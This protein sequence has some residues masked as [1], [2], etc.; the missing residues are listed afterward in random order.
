MRE[1]TPRARRADRGTTE[2]GV[3]DQDPTA[4]TEAAVTADEPVRTPASVRRGAKRRRKLVVSGVSAVVVVSL[5]G[6]GAAFAANRG[7]A[8]TY[9]TATATTG[10]VT[11]TVDAAGTVASAARADAAFSVAGTV[12]TVAVGVGDSVSAGDVLATLDLTE[13][14]DAVESAQE[15]LARAEQTLEDDLASQTSSSSTAAGLSSSAS[16][17]TSTS[18]RTSGTSA[19]IASITST[20]SS[21]TS[22]VSQ[23]VARVAGSSPVVTQAVATTTPSAAASSASAGGASPSAEVAQ[24]LEAVELAQQALLDGYDAATAAL[25]SSS[26]SIVG[27]QEACAAFLAATD[28]DLPSAPAGGEADEADDDTG[29]GAPAQDETSADRVDLEAALTT[30][31][32]AIT[33]ALGA[34]TDVDGAQHSL[35]DLAAQLDA[36]IQTAQEALA[37][38]QAGGSEGQTPG[39]SG[40]SGTGSGGSGTS[41]GSSGTPAGPSS[42]D[43]GSGSGV[44]GPGGASGTGGSGSGTT[45]P[46]SGGSATS[47][48]AASA[49]Q[50]LADR[51]AIDLAEAQV[52][53]AQ[54][55]AQRS[56]LTSPIA[57]TVAQ[58]ALAVGDQVEASSTSAVVTVLG[59]D[60]YVVETTVPLTAVVSLAV[61]Q[62][63][64]VTVSDDP[65]VRTGTV[66]SIGVL[67]TS[68]S[69][70]PEYPVTISLDPQDETLYE[71]SSAQ[72]SITVAGGT[73]VLVVPTSAVRATGTARTVAVLRDGKVTDVTVEVGAV[74]QETTEITSGLDAGDEVILADLTQEIVTDEES[75]TGLTGLGDSGSPQQRGQM[76]SGGG[77]Q[78]PA[79]GTGGPPS[80]G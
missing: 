38:D 15:T 47:Q 12:A 34:Q 62:E 3:A 78:F 72:A 11:Q 51:A 69:S 74:G 10:E 40:D 4:A 55:D 79:G 61:G 54:A 57:G 52:A 25:E 22:G 6:A 9:R 35:L 56:T 8:G 64:A 17:S 41:G 39:S 75:S 27:S 43:G 30:C 28:E 58:V 65:T 31:Q 29:A 68:T 44:T 46:T 2:Q 45:G 42:G 36:A 32:E 59:A 24:A 63:A 67:S 37:A 50:V 16:S 53:I 26:T 20:S 5:V 70:T 19:S 14:E 77:G 18:T 1:P 66:S 33:A 76:P 7:S 23:T 73:D 80:R 49:Q 60:G 21:G 13:L 48:Q 71:G